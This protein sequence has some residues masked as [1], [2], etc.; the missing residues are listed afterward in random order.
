MNLV[1]TDLSSNRTP[2]TRDGEE[3][4]HAAGRARDRAARIPRSTLCAH[5]AAG[6]KTGLIGREQ[7]SHEA[8]KKVN[9]F[10]GQAK[11]SVKILLDEGRLDGF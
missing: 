11:V 4:Q 6:A 3:L 7:R 9:I 2:R 5:R 10:S 1:S 8:C